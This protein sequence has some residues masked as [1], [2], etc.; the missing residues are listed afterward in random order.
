V[1]QA[2]E[3]LLAAPSSQATE[4]L[5][6]ASTEIAN[7][8]AAL[9][10]RLEALEA[11][12]PAARPAS[13]KQGTASPPKQGAAPSPSQAK[14]P[15][16]PGEAITTAELAELLGMKRNSLNERLRRTGGAQVGLVMEGWRCVGQSAPPEGGPL[17]WLWQQV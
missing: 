2:L 10:K 6:S 8:L 13:P 3:L 4:Q 7:Q 14:P 11:E 17:R 12:R 15:A 1:A 5:A 9:A 16:I